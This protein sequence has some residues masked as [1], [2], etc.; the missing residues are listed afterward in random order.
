MR[1]VVS[2]GSGATFD[3]PTPTKNPWTIVDYA[4]LS[5]GVVDVAGESLTMRGYRADG[6]AIES[7]PIVLTK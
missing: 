6:T 5:L 7:A 4:G 1:Y 2:G 3:S